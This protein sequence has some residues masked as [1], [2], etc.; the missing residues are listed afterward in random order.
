MYYASVAIIAL[1]VQIIINF[2]ALRKVEKTS[3]NDVRLKYRQYLFSLIVFYTADISWGYV[4]EHRW[5]TL[6]YIVTC[7]FFGSMVVSVL[8]WTKCVVAFSGSKGRRG[9]ALVIGGWVVFAFEMIVLTVNLF[10]PI[11]F[12]FSKDKEYLPCPARHIGLIMQMILFFVTSFYSLVMAVRSKGTQ[13]SHY[14]TICLSGIIMAIFIAF[15]MFFPLMPFYSMGCLFGTCLIHTFVYKDKEREQNKQIALAKQKA[16]KDGLTNVKNKLAYLETLG[17]LESAVE[18]GE[19]TEYGVVAF[20]VNGL[21]TINDTLGHEAGDEYIKTGCSLICHQF[22]HSPVFRIGGDE[23][24]AILKGS[25][26]E[27]RETL[28][29]SFKKQ[30]EENQKNGKVVVSC[31]LAVYDSTADSSYNDVFRR[32]DRFMY[33]HK[34]TLKAITENV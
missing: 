6:T 1:I 34:R 10:V 7:L 19:L 8:L 11:V 18:S 5:V 3:S 21:K 27:N 23:F 28:V 2:E 17:D 16:Y 25:D 24:V 14:R 22:D 9:K 30:I 20:D 4:Y 31:G 13:K 15:Q 12:S 26:Y 33:E 32:A 29:E